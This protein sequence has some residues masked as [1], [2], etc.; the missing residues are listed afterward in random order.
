MIAAMGAAGIKNP[1]GR[2]ILQMDLTQRRAD[3]EDAL[4][5][6]KFI[7][8]DE[9]RKNRWPALQPKAIADIAR[10]ALR[11]YTAPACPK[12]F[13]RG[14]IYAEN[15]SVVPCQA[16][17]A[18]GKRPPIGRWE[19]EI[20]AVLAAMERLRENALAGVNRQLCRPAFA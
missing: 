19:R 16:C 15:R 6:A 3:V 11:H 13:G 18:T 10:E 5:E 8:R 1:Q 12:C 9:A 2:A 4:A 17:D 7:V 14:M 20:R